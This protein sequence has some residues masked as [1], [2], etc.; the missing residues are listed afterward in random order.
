MQAH[1]PEVRRRHLERTVLLA[2]PV[3]E[4][5]DAAAHGERHKHALA[6]RLQHA[7]HGQV[8]Q[9]AVAEAGNVEEGDLEREGE[10]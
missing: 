5:A 1:K 2:L 7:Q 10:G 6:G 4:P 3:L 8:G 9:G